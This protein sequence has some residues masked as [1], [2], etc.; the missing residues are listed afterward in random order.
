MKDI[1]RKPLCFKRALVIC[2]LYLATRNGCTR[3]CTWKSRR[4]CKEY[5]NEL[6]LRCTWWVYI[7]E[8]RTEANYRRWLLTLGTLESLLSN[9]PK[10]QHLADGACHRHGIDFSSILS[11]CQN[12]DKYEQ[13][14]SRRSCALGLRSIESRRRS[15]PRHTWYTGEFDRCNGLQ[16]YQLRSAHSTTVRIWCAK[17]WIY[18]YVSMLLLCVRDRLDNIQDSNIFEG[19]PEWVKQLVVDMGPRT[20]GFR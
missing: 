13:H 1:S 7:F 16:V 4:L 6:K 9:A 3:G 15:Y 20:V 8:P 11:V 12:F 2:S 10:Y 19:Y 5:T 17:G 18:L 14:L